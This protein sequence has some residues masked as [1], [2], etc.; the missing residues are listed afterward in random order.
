MCPAALGLNRCLPA[1]PPALL[2]G[3]AQREVLLLGLR[4][5]VKPGIHAGELRQLPPQD[6]VALEVQPCQAR[7][8]KEHSRKRLE[9]ARPTPSHVCGTQG[10]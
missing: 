9:P 4:E 2:V 3:E 5:A 6:R 7:A 10:F 1:L 8:G